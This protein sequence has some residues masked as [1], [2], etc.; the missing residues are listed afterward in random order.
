MSRSFTFATALAIAFILLASYPASAFRPSIAPQDSSPLRGPITWRVILCQFKDSAAL[1]KQ[2]GISPQ[3]LQNV[4]YYKDLFFTPGAGG[5]QDW[6]RTVS[7]GL[8]SVDGDV[9]GWYTELYTHQQTVSRSRFQH[10][11]DCV[12]AAASPPVGPGYPPQPAPYI[13]PKDDRVYVIT[14]PGNDLVGFD[15]VGA[16]GQDWGM[17]QKTNGTLYTTKTTALREIAHEFGHG[18]GLAHSFN[19]DLAWKPAGWGAPGEYGNA[20]DIMS[21]RSAFG[22]ASTEFG[23]GAAGLD[24]HHLDDLGWVPM[25]RII[26][27]GEDGITSR[28]VRLV[29]LTHPHAKGYVIARVLFDQNDSFHYYT[30]EYRVADGLDSAMSHGGKYASQMIE[31]N[32]VAWEANYDPGTPKSPHKLYVT[33]LQRDL[34]GKWGG[35]GQGPP[36]QSL[37]KHGVTI[38]VKQ[39]ASDHAIVEITTKF[40]QD[41]KPGYVWRLASPSDYVCVTAATRD[42]AKDENAAPHVVGESCAHSYVRRDAYSGDKVCVTK[43]QREQTVADNAAADSRVRWNEYGPLTCKPGYVWRNAD[44]SDYICVTETTRDQTAA[45]NAAAASHTSGD[46]CKPSYAPRDAFH[47]DNVCV[48]EAQRDQAQADNAAGPGRVQK[49][50]S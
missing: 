20:W 25:N 19:D 49:T 23:P 30:V 43:E 17:H 14:S 6:V 13:V 32:E 46:T 34:S 8:A 50:N 18:I 39:L 3:P 48:T 7:N 29:A 5:M 1:A 31:I 47:G 35:T 11:S 44:T 22:S 16:V 41:C 36:V 26:N 45:E 9:H 37:D 28:S 27:I 21:D 15:N 4:E 24:A 2:Y 12:A 42:Q 40:R 10:L 38:A 33:F